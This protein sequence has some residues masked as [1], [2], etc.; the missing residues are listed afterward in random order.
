MGSLF[1]R[2][3]RALVFLSV[4]LGPRLS[5]LGRSDM[6]TVARLAFFSGLWPVNKTELLSLWPKGFGQ[7]LGSGMR[8]VD[9]V[10]V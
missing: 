7:E 5:S 1:V 6:V 2:R 8:S 3:E 9:R 10:L 4:G